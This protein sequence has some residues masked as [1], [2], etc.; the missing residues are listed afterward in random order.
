M[1]E[2]VHELPTLDFETIQCRNTGTL[3]IETGD[4]EH[5]DETAAVQI[6]SDGCRSGVHVQ[7][8][9]A[10]PGDGTDAS[11][12]V[13]LSPSGAEDLAD[14]LRNGTPMQFSKSHATIWLRMG[15][16]YHDGLGRDND[17]TSGELEYSGGGSLSVTVS[18]DGTD[19]RM[20]AAALLDDDE[21]EWL[22]DV[23]ESEA[24]LARNYEPI[25]TDDADAE[26]PNPRIPAKWKRTVTTLGVTG[27]AGYLGLRVMNAVAGSVTING[28]PM[29]P[30][31]VVEVTP[32]VLA[33]LLIVGLV[34]AL[35]G[36]YMPGAGG[37]P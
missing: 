10:M 31:G 2:A 17:R 36:G 13:Y 6:S 14:A 25:T 24:E 34:H 23:L 18:D 27:V 7:I 22:A 12:T 28:E 37:R 5:H 19:S 8:G 3:I 1:T 21:R 29:P 9:K 16:L 26:E 35:I 33:L 30:L 4:I 15:W 11:T 20:T 32:V